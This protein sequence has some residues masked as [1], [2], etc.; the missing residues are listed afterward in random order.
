MDELSETAKGAMRAAGIGG[1]IAIA[2]GIIQQRYHTVGEWLRAVL[3]GALVAGGVGLLVTGSMTD[4]Q[5][6]F[7][8]GTVALIAEPLL[9]GIWGFGKQFKSDPVKFLKTISDAVRGRG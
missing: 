1:G 5:M 4:A 7:T 9:D 8:A 3:A 6:W 2:A